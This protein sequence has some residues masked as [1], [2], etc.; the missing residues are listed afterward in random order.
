MRTHRSFNFNYFFGLLNTVNYLF[1]PKKIAM[2][3]PTLIYNESER[4][5][6]N[7]ADDL[8]MLLKSV[9][10]GTYKDL[11]NSYYIGA[12]LKAAGEIKPVGCEYRKKDIAGKGNGNRTKNRI[13]VV[14]DTTTGKPVEGLAYL[15]RHDDRVLKLA[16]GFFKRAEM[17]RK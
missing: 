2:G 14:V 8:G 11:P 13:I 5:N 12:E 17:L 16:P 7:I 9:D 6:V 1:I 4:E 15:W 10:K 3:A